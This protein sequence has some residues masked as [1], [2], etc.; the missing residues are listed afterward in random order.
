MSAVLQ[1]A[2]LAILTERLG[3][4][5]SKVRAE[6]TADPARAVRVLTFALEAPAVV[7]RAGFAIARFRQ[8]FDPA[9]ES[10]APAPLSAADLEAGLIWARAHTISPRVL[11]ILEL[12]LEAARERDAIE[13]AEAALA[14]EAEREQYGPPAR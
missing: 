1:L 7:N 12:E 11:A 3:I 9:P 5:S 13:A 8:G 10:E 4:L 6:L 14:L 2:E